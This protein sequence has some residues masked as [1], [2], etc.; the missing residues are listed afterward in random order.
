MRLSSSPRRPAKIGRNGCVTLLDRRHPPLLIAP[1]PTERAQKTRQS[2]RRRR[3]RQSYVHTRRRRRLDAARPS[4]RPEQHAPSVLDPR[5][6]TAPGPASATA[7]A[8]A[9]ALPTIEGRQARSRGKHIAHEHPGPRVRHEQCGADEKRVGADTRGGL[10]GRC[11]GREAAAGEETARGKSSRS[12]MAVPSMVSAFRAKRLS[13]RADG[14]AS[15]RRSRSLLSC[16]RTPRVD[17]HR[18]ANFQ[19]IQ[20]QARDMHPHLPVQQPTPQGV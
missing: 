15:E 14:R 3:T 11:P 9:T 6:P 20:G 19:D 18:A 7:T 10:E 12:S 17:A 1:P 13:G 16:S 5:T 8:T 2:A 4:S